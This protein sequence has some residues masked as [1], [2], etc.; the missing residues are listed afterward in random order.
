MIPNTVL[1]MATQ[2]QS[3][4]WQEQK[5]WA[6]WKIYGRGNTQKLWVTTM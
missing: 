1:V 4:Q 2:T 5:E 6:W 3:I